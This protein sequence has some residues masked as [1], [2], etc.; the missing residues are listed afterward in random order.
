ML[1]RDRARRLAE[2][3]LRA[4][5]ADETEVVVEQTEQE[6]N[7]FTADHP[8]QNLVRLLSRVSVRVR[9]DGH[10]GKASTGT[11]TDDA[12]LDI[13]ALDDALLRFAQLDP[14]THHIVELSV[15]GGLTNAEIATILG[16]TK[17]VIEG[18]LKLA[19]KWL[20]DEM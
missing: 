11:A 8:V 19:R 16:V 7:R 15:F 9:V 17:R 12:P 13:V 14:P 3:A 6:L 2:T 5:T 18:D 20:A 10:E 1:D 4:S